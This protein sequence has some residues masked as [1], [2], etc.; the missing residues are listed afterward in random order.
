MPVREATWRTA[1]GSVGPI[2]TR[3]PDETAADASLL[4]RSLLPPV[5]ASVARCSFF[6]DRRETDRAIS[7]VRRKQ[8]A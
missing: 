2:T 4:A 3:E 5:S 8:R 6:Q 1:C 7:A